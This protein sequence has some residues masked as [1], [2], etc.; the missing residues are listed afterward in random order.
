M[1]SGTFQRGKIGLMGRSFPALSRWSWSWSSPTPLAFALS[2]KPVAQKMLPERD[3]GSQAKLP[4]VERPEPRANHQFQKCFALLDWCIKKREI[5]VN[6]VCVSFA[7]LNVSVVISMTVGDWKT[8][9][10]D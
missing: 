1:R 2:A 8:T 6:I 5:I 10:C 3:D 9:V 4:E 7:V